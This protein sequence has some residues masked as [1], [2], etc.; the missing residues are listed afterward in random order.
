[1]L[2]LNLC[3]PVRDTVVVYGGLARDSSMQNNFYLLSLSRRSVDQLIIASGAVIERHERASALTSTCSH[4]PLYCAGIT[5]APR[6]RH[7]A[8]MLGNDLLVVGGVS[9][10][11]GLKSTPPPFV[12]R[13]LGSLRTQVGSCSRRCADD[14][15]AQAHVRAHIG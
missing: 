8:A 14:A 12:V 4:M 9:M 1:M 3:A 7:C 6:A 11:D 15:D 10:Q 13:D 2:F 5:P